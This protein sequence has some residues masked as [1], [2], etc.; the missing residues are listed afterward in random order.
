MQ[1]VT[2]AVWQLAEEALD[3]GRPGDFNQALMELGATVCT[4]KNPQCETCPV[5]EVCLA[6]RRACKTANRKQLADIEEGQFHKV[7]EASESADFAVFAPSYLTYVKRKKDPKL[8][9]GGS[10]DVFRLVASLRKKSNF[11]M[12]QLKKTIFLQGNT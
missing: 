6:R 1:A 2:K 5:S 7:I 10:S 3:P 11:L 9:V 8:G 12:W 4:P